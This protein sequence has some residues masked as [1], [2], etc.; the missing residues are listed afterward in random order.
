MPFVETYSVDFSNGNL[1][2]SLNQ[3]GWPD[4]VFRQTAEGHSERIADASG[5][6]LQMTRNCDEGK[7][8]D[9]A[10]TQTPQRPHAIACMLY[11][12]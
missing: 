10:K 5:I 2:P 3:R 7:I 1:H 8:N 11:P 6:T 9:G 4:M 12:L